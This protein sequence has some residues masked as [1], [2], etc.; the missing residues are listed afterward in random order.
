M[1]FQCGSAAPVRCLHRLDA[2]NDF[3]FNP[4]S[5]QF[6][7]RLFENLTQLQ[8]DAELVPDS[9]NHLRAEQ[10]V[11]AQLKEV[12]SYVHGLHAKQLANDLADT[13][14]YLCLWRIRVMGSSLILTK[15]A[16]TM[17]LGK[18]LPRYSDHSTPSAP[19]SVTRYATSCFS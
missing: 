1:M 8:L 16:G 14:L 10:R 2:K 6:D 15:I 3:F 17:Y 4:A 19:S 7:A 18:D 12:V 5:Q 11:A 9:R 13:L